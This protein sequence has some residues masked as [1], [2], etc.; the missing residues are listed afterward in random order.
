MHQALFISEI[1]LDIVSAPSLPRQSLAALART[2]KT[3]HEPAM[4]AL[5][6]DMHGIEPL[7]G[8]VTRLHPMI[9]PAAKWFGS[10]LDGTEPLSEYETSH[11]LRH[12]ARVRSL[13]IGIW[14]PYHLL[15]VLRVEACLFPRLL[16][17]DWRPG[18]STRL[19]LFLSP[20]L[21]RF[22]LDRRV[23]LVHSNLTFIATHCHVLENLFLGNSERGAKYYKQSPQ[24]EI[25]R[26]CSRLKHLRCPS[27]DSAAWKHLS[28]LPTL[29]AV[30]ICGGLD[31]AQLNR[32]N[33][34]FTPFLNVTTLYFDVKSAS[35]IITLIQH[36]EFPSL[37]KF[38]MYVVIL[39]WAE[40]EQLFHALS[41]CKAC[42]TLEDITIYSRRAEDGHSYE[43]WTAIRRFLCIPQLR[44]LSLTAHCPIYLDNNLLLEAMSSWPY[45]CHLDL[46]DQ[47][48]PTSPPTVSF[49]GLFSALRLCPHLRYLKTHMDAVNIDIIPTSDSFQ[50]ASLRM[51]DV[52]SSDVADVEAVA[53]IIFLKLPRVRRVSFDT[54][55]GSELGWEEINWQLR[56][57]EAFGYELVVA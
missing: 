23:R 6:A 32:D 2:C 3:F 9:Y 16:T 40:A 46:M 12:A 39:P 45:I 19:H 17:L 44:I 36:S 11:F 48:S 5:W 50:H 10:K 57:F 7:L 31:K 25:I 54:K 1:F 18:T 49:C 33:I 53:R 42:H 56:M 30:S 37:K 20:T 47:R 34:N 35:D 21:R 24:S 38:V 13:V 26:S 14:C 22:E 28:N 41:W 51:L 55:G 29:V 52:G 27:L 15:P 43:P 4:D 8:C